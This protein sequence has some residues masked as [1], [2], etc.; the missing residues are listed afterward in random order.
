M[1][2]SRPVPAR[3]PYSST[4]PHNPVYTV[5]MS[6]WGASPKPGPGHPHHLSHHQRAI[7]HPELSYTRIYS[8]KAPT[9]SVTTRFHSAPSLRFSSQIPPSPFPSV[10]HRQQ[11]INNNNPPIH[12]PHPINTA[13]P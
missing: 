10:F 12:T 9:L 13:A 11:G 1:E 8:F 2:P 5:F 4:P 6:H 3:N 7:D